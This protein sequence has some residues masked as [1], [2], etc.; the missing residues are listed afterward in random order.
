M[1]VYK[2]GDFYNCFT[3]AIKKGPPRHTLCITGTRMEDDEHHL[4][5]IT[6]G[7]QTRCYLIRIK[8]DLTL[9][10]G[11]SSASTLQQSVVKL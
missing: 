4:S 8:N 1:K 7:F 10:E 5:L 6:N 2:Q 11:V 3:C 9:M